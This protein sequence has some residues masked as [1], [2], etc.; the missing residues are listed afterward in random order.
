MLGTLQ[1]LGDVVRLS[2]KSLSERRL[3]ALLTILGIAIGPLAL[4]MISSVVEGYGEYVIGQ[5]EGLGQNAVVLFPSSGYRFSG[6]DLNAIR[7]L[8]H[9]TRAEPFYS[10]QAQ[11]RVGGEDRLVFVYAI[12]VDM[13][14]ESVRGL[15]IMKGA[16]PS[17]SDYL[18]AVVGYK[19]AHDGNGNLVYDVGDVLTLT[20]LRAGGGRG[21]IRRV[22]VVVGAILKEFGGAFVLSPDVTVF[23]PLEAGQRVLG[24]GE[25]SGI[26]VLAKGSEYVAPLTEELRALYGSS[27][28]IISF[29][30]IANVV[31]SVVSAINFIS[32]SASLSAFAVAA[33]GVA[34]TMITSVIERTR[35]IGVLKALGFTDAQV[36]MMV[37]AESILMGS[38]GGFIG[39]VL[40]ALGAHALSA[41]G[42]EVRAAAQVVMTIRAPPKVTLTGA[43]RAFALTIFTSVLG[44]VF[45][46]YRAA[47]IPPAVALRYE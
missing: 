1:F 31:N 10:I 4:V 21:E 30:S 25:W 18:K 7:S 28:E 9:V 43:S 36:M 3:R 37:F 16:I 23:L 2:F 19:V 44:G 13:V 6:A 20:F 32:F 47:K 42:F 39:V 38:I 34:A 40:G 27:A 11:V 14:F 45:P 5:V 8:D 41:I 46:A 17:E 35:E 24:I 12:P 15:E 26:F 33:A 22:S 29:Q